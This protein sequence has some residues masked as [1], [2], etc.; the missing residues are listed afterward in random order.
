M[1]AISAGLYAS[2]ALKADGTVVGWGYTPL[3][4]VPPGLSN[5][6]AIDAGYQHGLALKSDGRV[7]AW[8]DNLYGQAN[9]PPGLSNVV[10]ISGGCD[11]SLALTGDGRVVGWGYNEYGQTS[12]PAELG[13]GKVLAI[14]AGGYHSLALKGA[15]DLVITVQP[16]SQTVTNGADVTFTVAVVGPGPLSYQWRK[17]TTNLLDG[18]TVS[19]ATTATLALSNVQL[20]AAGDYTVMVIGTWG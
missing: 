8:G 20:A 7:V 3:A 14:S 16:L 6:V 9:V 5:V 12:P 4:T 18:G 13:I 1:V 2:V 15:T 10:A 19:G 17:G 11:H